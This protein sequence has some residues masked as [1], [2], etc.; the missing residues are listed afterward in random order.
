MRLK[1]QKRIIINQKWN[2]MWV[3]RRKWT[4]NEL[5]YSKCTGNSSISDL[6]NK[7]QNPQKCETLNDHFTSTGPN[8]ASKL[9]SGN[10][11]FDSYTKPVSTT[12]NLQHTSATEVL[13][14]LGKTR[15]LALITSHFGF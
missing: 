10:A 14:L 4:I 11:S 12:F 5:T 7:T 15:P 9:P 1:W 3:T 13:K 6:K 8:L 2:K